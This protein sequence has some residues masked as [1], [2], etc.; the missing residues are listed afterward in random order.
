V[1]GEW[2]VE[3]SIVNDLRDAIERPNGTLAI[4]NQNV[5]EGNQEIQQA[6]A[7]IPTEPLEELIDGVTFPA[8][9]VGESLQKTFKDGDNIQ[10]DVGGVT[11][12]GLH[13]KV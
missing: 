12:T 11:R 9:S 3:K 8:G 2:I 1:Y 7:T 10:V 6:I 5:G 13:T 4:L